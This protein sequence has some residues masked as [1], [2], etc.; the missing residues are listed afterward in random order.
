VRNRNI[1][2]ANVELKPPRVSIIIL[3]WN[4]LEDTVECLESLKKITYPNY[5]IIVVDNGSKGNDSVVL[6]ERFGD[7]IHLIKNAK[8]YGYAGG[9]N[10]GINYALLNS[11]SS[12]FLLLNNDTVVAPDFLT[13]MVMV[14]ETD[15]AIGIT[16]PLVYYYD[17]PKHIQMVGAKV[18]MWTGRTAVIGFNQLDKGQYT[19]QREIDYSGPC[20]LIRKAVVQEVGLFDESFFC[21][22]EDVDYSVRA[23]EVGYKV[24]YAPEAKMWHKNPMIGKVWRKALLTRKTSHLNYYYGVRNNF[25]FMRK[26]ASKW[27]YRSFLICFFGY[28]FWVRHAVCLL[29]YR[30]IKLLI[31][32]YRGLN[33]GMFSSEGGARFYIGS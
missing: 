31:A 21:Y 22:W 1:A 18:N 32:F 7:Y 19:K 2:L 29:Y 15:T 9:V 14:A 17:F 6:K 12:Y 20:W 13:Q 4:G 10:I 33:D 11:E 3:N 28:F 24:V 8:N 23:K 5:E 27:Q 30:D 16:C 26:H 25:K